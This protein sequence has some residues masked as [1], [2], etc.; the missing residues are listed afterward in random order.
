MSYC[1][2][3]PDTFEFYVAD[4]LRVLRVSVLLSRGHCPLCQQA[5]AGE[6]YLHLLPLF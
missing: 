3:L 5:P 6:F 2:T 4:Q 1:C